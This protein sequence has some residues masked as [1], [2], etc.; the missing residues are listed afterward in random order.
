[1]NTYTETLSEVVERELAYW[2][3]E[4][5]WSR[6]R[7]AED[8]QDRRAY[9]RSCMAGAPAET[10]PLPRFTAWDIVRALWKGQGV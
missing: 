2:R 1:M 6:E 9:F 5:Q 3:D 7:E 4:C 8:E 10:L